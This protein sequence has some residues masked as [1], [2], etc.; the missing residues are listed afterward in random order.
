MAEKIFTPE[1]GSQ[2]TVEELLLALPIT[3]IKNNRP[4]GMSFRP[5]LEGD[6]IRYV[7]LYQCVANKDALVVKAENPWQA[8]ADMC[9][10]LLTSKLVVEIKTS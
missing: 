5:I 9:Q 8:L 1:T 6:L 2:F 4:Y 10:L 7:V 3:I